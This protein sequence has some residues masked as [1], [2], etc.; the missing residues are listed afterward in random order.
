MTKIVL[1][2]L[3]NLQNENTAINTINDNSD[4]IVAAIDNTLSRDGTAPNQMAAS[5]DMNSHRILNLPFPNSNTDPIRLQDILDAGKGVGIPN[6]GLTGQILTKNT[7]TSYDVSWQNSSGGVTPGQVNGYLLGTDGTTASWRGFNQSVTGSRIR[8]WNAKV[9]E[10]ISVSD[11]TGWTGDGITADD[12][13]WNAAI[14]Y[15]NAVGNITIEMPNGKSYINAA[16]TPITNSG[17]FIK[18]KSPGASKVILNPTVVGGTFQWGTDLIAVDNGG[19]VEMGITYNGTPTSSSI[20]FDLHFAARL[21]F[22]NL[23]IENV[24]CLA[25]F[26]NA[27]T[28]YCSTIHFNEIIGWGTNVSIPLFNIFYMVG[29]IVTNCDI[30]NNVPGPVGNNPI[31]TVPGRHFISIAGAGD[32][33]TMIVADTLFQRFDAAFA[34]N[35]SAGHVSQN[36]FID[37]CIGDYMKNYGIVTS[38]TG[39]GSFVV[40]LNVTNC[41]LTV[42]EGRA[43]FLTGSGGGVNRAHSFVG[44][45]FF[46]CGL[47]CVRID[48][49]C[50]APINFIGNQI[51]G[52]NRLNSGANTV[53]ITTGAKGFNFVGNRIGDDT[54][55]MIG[56]NLAGFGIDLQADCDDFTITGNTLNGTVGGATV[57]A[58][59][60]GSTRRLFTNNVGGPNVTA[61]LA[62]P[63]SNVPWVNT[64]PFRTSIYSFGGTVSGIS[65]NGANLTGMGSG[66]VN[67]GPGE[68]VTWNYS[69]VPSVTYFNER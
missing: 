41:W 3:A 18:G 43:V 35:A 34:L 60:T 11:F 53:E 10:T 16:L 20:V 6:G 21:I 38:A 54:S 48:N 47:D 29:L 8:T 59:S 17:V 40:G 2:D 30:F 57:A 37:N 7:N 26:G 62:V 12:V 56:Y 22:T 67:V 58:N 49:T 61:A 4:V 31:S 69:A 39:A 5:L 36:F 1:T 28:A 64:T 14:V 45:K 23:R 19:M 44:N 32:Y 33:D 24:A 13:A 25:K 55:S 65:H 42:W 51:H 50:N 52:A 68:T 27:S 9:A 63:T 46:L 15:A 66:T